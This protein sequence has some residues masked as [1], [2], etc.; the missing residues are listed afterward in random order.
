MPNDYG[1]TTS[2]VKPVPYKPPKPPVLTPPTTPPVWTPTP[3]P[4]GTPTPGPF[5]GGYT[6]PAPTPTPAQNYQAPGSHQSG[7][8]GGLMGNLPAPAYGGG[9]PT[10]PAATGGGGGGGGNT[11]NGW[12][13]VDRSP[14]GNILVLENGVPTAYDPWGNKIPHLYFGPAGGDPNG[15]SGGGGGGTAA[16][17]APTTPALPTPPGST[18][19]TW[20]SPPTGSP[21]LQLPGNFLSYMS[22]AERSQ[23]AD[24]LRGAGFQATGAYSTYGPSDWLRPTQFDQNDLNSL[25]LNGN[26]REWLRWFLGNMGYGL[27]YQLPAGYQP[28]TGLPTAPQYPLPPVPPGTP[29]P[30]PDPYIP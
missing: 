15:G 9:Y 24:T 7:V 10:P 29:A 17:V 25:A 19:T 3:S 23:L 4:Y 5:G 6:P 30:V 28:G 11:Y 1:G 21:Y 13:I 16:P 12:P 26:V 14:G 18:P 2:P 22:D 8:N 27:S 20:Y